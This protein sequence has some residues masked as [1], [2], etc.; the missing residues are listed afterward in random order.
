[1]MQKFSA[2]LFAAAA[3][4]MLSGFHGHCGASTPEA[5]A[6]QAARFAHS[7]AD[8]FLDDVDASD[9]Q[10]ARVHQLTDRVI[11]QAMP[12]VPEHQLAKQ[13]L[14]AQWKS[15]NPDPVKVH[16]IIDERIDAVRKVIH[17]GADAV[18]ELHNLLTPEQRKTID[19]KL[20]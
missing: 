19:E 18:I 3:F 10:R 12:L 6:K 15:K 5:R 9:E 2:G 8:D 13:E 1:M 7:R 4:V 16:S 17:S 20:E 11:D 14:I